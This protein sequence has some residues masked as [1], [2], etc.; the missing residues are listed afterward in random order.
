ML[1]KPHSS[2]PENTHPHGEHLKESI[3]GWDDS[4]SE[5]IEPTMR[6]MDYELGDR[7]LTISEAFHFGD[8]VAIAHNPSRVFDDIHRTTLPINSPNLS[9]P[10]IL[11]T[12]KRVASIEDLY[13]P[14]KSFTVTEIFT[15]SPKTPRFRTVSVTEPLGEFSEESL[16]IREG[17]ILS[18]SAQTYPDIYEAPFS[19]VRRVRRIRRR[20]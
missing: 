18:Q 12:A 14:D 15:R 10:L 5:V 11:S 17:E 3:S 20:F 13:L 6:D 19:I 2:T 1:H 16:D 8:A 4:S 9:T 7:T